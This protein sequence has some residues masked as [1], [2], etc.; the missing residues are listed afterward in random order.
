MR[1]TRHGVGL[2]PLVLGVVL[3][4]AVVA[5]ALA[6]ESWDAVYMA[7]AKVGHVHTYVQPV[8]DRGRDLLRV[9]VDME[10]SFKRLKD[11]ITIELQLRDDRDA[12]GERAPARHPD[13]GQQAGD[14]G[15]SAT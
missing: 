14:A 2:G 9:R 5:S 3:P 4:L 15:P 10:L 8:K 6:Q 11:Q 7:G 1:R 12:R 13:A